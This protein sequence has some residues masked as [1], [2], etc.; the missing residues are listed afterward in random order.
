M[1]PFRNGENQRRGRG[2]GRETNSRDLGSGEEEVTSTKA[3]TAGR[4]Q[5]ISG[6]GQGGVYT[7]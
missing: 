6:I 4:T 1:V 3:D 2:L 5:S 7:I